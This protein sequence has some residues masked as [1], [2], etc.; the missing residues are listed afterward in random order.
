MANKKALVSN[1]VKGSVLTITSNPF[2]KKIENLLSMC[3]HLYIND[4]GQY[5]AIYFDDFHE[6]DLRNIAKLDKKLKENGLRA[7]VVEPIKFEYQVKKDVVL[8]DVCPSYLSRQ[9][10]SFE[11][12]IAFMGMTTEVDR[13]MS[14]YYSKEN[15][16]L[17]KAQKEEER[18]IADEYEEEKRV[19][20]EECKDF[21]REPTAEELAEIE[22]EL[23]G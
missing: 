1:A 4:K 12:Y 22:L 9:G 3:M 23:V 17:R 15:R 7:K 8:A 16:E 2:G 11:E 5:V 14:G 19:V 21:D 6:D 13:D 20:R 18:E 10:K